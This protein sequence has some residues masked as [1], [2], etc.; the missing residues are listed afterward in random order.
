MDP[1]ELNAIVEQER[2][3]SRAAHAAYEALR[4]FPPAEQARILAVLHVMVEQAASAMP[5][6]RATP[7]VTFS[8]PEATS[9]RSAPQ[10]EA[11]PSPEEEED[12]VDDNDGSAGRSEGITETVLRILR[13]SYPRRM[14]TPDIIN[15]VQR[16]NPS[17]SNEYVHQVVSRLFRRAD[18]PLLRSGSKGFFKYAAKPVRGDGDIL[19]ET[20]NSRNKEAGM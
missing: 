1:L 16:E 12:Y 4:G 3:R 13:N 8:L 7:P 19:V 11:S 14:S 18:K 17:I 2:A 6:G 10:H 20:P 9:P 15:A 5:S